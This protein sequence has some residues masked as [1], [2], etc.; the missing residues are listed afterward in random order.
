MVDIVEE[1]IELH[2]I[3]TR[4]LVEEAKK[5]KQLERI[6]KRQN[7]L[8]KKCENFVLGYKLVVTQIP[9]DK[10]T[11]ILN[12]LAIIKIALKPVKTST[13]T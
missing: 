7:D 9:R 5:L 4:D 1:E 6:K 2:L 11:V 13:L 12:T 3:D 8:L 10:S